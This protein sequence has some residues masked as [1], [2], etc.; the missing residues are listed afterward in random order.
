MKNQICMKEG[1]KMNAVVVNKNLA[2]GGTQASHT[3]AMTVFAVAAF[4]TSLM[5]G[6]QDVSAARFLA[7][8]EP[9]LI[10]TFGL[11]VGLIA[12]ALVQAIYGINL[13]PMR[14]AR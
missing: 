14:G 10:V 12:L 11:V 8:A 9:A 1:T 6:S 7:I 4:L 5:L 13:A 2:S 3:K